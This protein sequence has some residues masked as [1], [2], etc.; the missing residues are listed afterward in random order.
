MK[1]AFILVILAVFCI[2]M[3]MGTASA[4]KTYSK[5]ME[6]KKYNKNY[7]KKIKGGYIGYYLSNKYDSQCGKSL[8]VGIS[9]HKYKI[10]KV[11]GKV[12]GKWYTLKRILIKSLK[13]PVFKFNK[14]SKIKVY[15]KKMT[16]SEVK[17]ANKYER[18]GA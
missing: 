10:S 3:F 4:T 9:K 2:G 15:Y 18:G 17:W 16:A 13:E 6:I 11:K 5:T 14:Y 12:G 7:F 1:K 8:S